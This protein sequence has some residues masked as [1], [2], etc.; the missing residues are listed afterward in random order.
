MRLFG[1]KTV[2][3]SALA[4]PPEEKYTRYTHRHSRAQVQ[5]VKYAS[6][7]ATQHCQTTHVSPK[8]AVSRKPAPVTQE[9]SLADQLHSEEQITTALLRR[10]LPLRFA[11]IDARTREIARE[12]A[13]ELQAQNR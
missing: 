10:A 12:G 9:A 4:Q 8:R 3:K 13:A 11:E 5:P 7:P 2:E 6:E 1:S